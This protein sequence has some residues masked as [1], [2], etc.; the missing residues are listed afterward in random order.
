MS[1]WALDL[2]TTNSAIARWDDQRGQP[3]LVELGDICRKPEGD[4]ALEAPRLVPSAVDIV[5]DPGLLDRVGRWPWVARRMFL[6]RHAVIGR[7][8]L[9]RNQGVARPSFVPSFKTALYGEPLRPLARVGKRQV[10]AR[11]AARAFLRELLAELKRTTGHRV[12]DLTVTAPVSA[13]E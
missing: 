6:G 4:D 8:A 10:T 3:A 1:G 11:E 13:F 12:R 2:G 5:D 7:T 9:E